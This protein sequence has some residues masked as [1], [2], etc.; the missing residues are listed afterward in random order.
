MTRRMDL[1]IEAFP[2]SS[3]IDPDLPIF[4]GAVFRLANQ[5]FPSY[6]EFTKFLGWELKFLSH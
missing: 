4:T 5:W 3:F 6:S 1:H 2:Y